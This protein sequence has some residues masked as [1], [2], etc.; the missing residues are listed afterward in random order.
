M[1]LGK[2]MILLA[3][4]VIQS[5]QESTTASPPK[6]ETSLM[7]PSERFE[8]L[9]VDVQMARIFPDGKTFADCI[10]KYG[11]DYI[12]DNYEE[13]KALETFDLKTFVLDHFELPP[14]PES[15]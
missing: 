10:P 6:A 12:T 4:V 11:S 5:C 2:L 14:Q 7:A 1:K 15:L 13:A 9:F 8:S 3:F